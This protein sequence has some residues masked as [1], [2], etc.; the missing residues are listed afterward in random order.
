M[1]SVHGGVSCPLCG[2]EAAEIIFENDGS[3]AHLECYRCSCPFSD[4]SVTF[5]G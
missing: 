4:P 1:P 5:G 2:C 3:I